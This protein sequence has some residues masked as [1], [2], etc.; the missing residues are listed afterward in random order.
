VYILLTEDP[1]DFDAVKSIIRRL[2]GNPS[3]PVRGK[4][5]NGAGE[6]LKRGAPSIDALLDKNTAGCIVVHDCDGETIERRHQRVIAEV[7]QKVKK[8]GVFCAVIPKQEIEAWILADIDCVTKVFPGWRPA[9]QYLNPEAVPKAKEELIR[10]SRGQNMRPR[11]STADNKEIAKV[12]DLK[13]VRAK[14]PSF[15]PLATLI[16][17]GTGNV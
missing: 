8:R 3:V 15:L 7:F 1:T 12:L 5:F 17:Q 16:E 6:L 9:R 11:Y 4:G 10:L 14:C 13:A 2:A